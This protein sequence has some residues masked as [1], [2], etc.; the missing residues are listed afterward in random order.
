MA[1]TNSYDRLKRLELLAAQLKDDGPC[2]VGDLAE[3]HNVSERTI[4]RDL[5]LMRDQG[6]PIDS[7]RGRGGGVRLDRT[8]GVGRLNLSYAESVDLLISI[9]VAEQLKSPIF[10]ANLGAVRRQLIAS[11]SPDKRRRVENL[12]SRILIGTTASTNVQQTIKGA[13]RPVIQRLHQSFLDQTTLAIRYQKD[14]GETSKRV[15]EAH[16]MLL[17]YPVWYVLA[18]DHLRG[19]PRTFRCDRI[20]NTALSDKRFRLLPKSEFSQV[21]DWHDLLI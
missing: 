12:K 11:F 14:S 6:L 18:F 4:A 20:R 9:A 17:K 8:W 1:R 19:E 7:D 16:Y 5:Q 21:L 13:A 2:T 10:L 3:R 15:I